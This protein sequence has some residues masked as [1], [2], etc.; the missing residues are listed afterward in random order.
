MLNSVLPR[1]EFVRC[2]LPTARLGVVL[3][4]P[5]VRLAVVRTSW[6]TRDEPV[7]TQSGAEKVSVEEVLQG[8]EVSAVNVSR[9]TREDPRR[10]AQGEDRRMKLSECLC[11]AQPVVAGRE[12]LVGCLLASRKSPDACAG[13]RACRAKA[14]HDL[15]GQ[16]S[17]SCF[18]SLGADSVNWFCLRKNTLP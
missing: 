7:C 2:Y 1:P 14:R 6:W 16:S 10:C 4:M 3:T 17:G 9:G 18:R 13:V 8:R 11:G 12:I 15:A 5:G